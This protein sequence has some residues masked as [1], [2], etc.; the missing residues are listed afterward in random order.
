MEHKVN[1]N[2]LGLLKP[3]RPE[4]KFL[5]STREAL[6]IKLPSTDVTRGPLLSCVSSASVG[7]TMV[8]EA[9]KILSRLSRQ[10]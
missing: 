9:P 2:I 3:A 8:A 10:P 4:E 7:G 5:E 1:L 6:L